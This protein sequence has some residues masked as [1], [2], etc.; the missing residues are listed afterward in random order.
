MAEWIAAGAAAMA[1][2]VFTAVLLAALRELKRRLG[3]FEQTV[4]RIEAEAVPLL[5]EIR[6]LAGEA[7]RTA[8]QAGRQLDRVGRLLKAAEQWEEAV[9]RSG[10][11]ACRI[12]DSVDRAA[13][14]RAEQAIRNGQAW[15][16][17]ALDWAERVWSIWKWWQTKR[18]EPPSPVRMKDDMRDP[19]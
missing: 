9:R 1:W 4:Q 18:A 6:G 5:R 17:D 13:A 16:G 10:E 7:A 11:T 15:I 19:D 8:E 3:R 14:A 12:A 2:I